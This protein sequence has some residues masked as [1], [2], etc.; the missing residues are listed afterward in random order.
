[1]NTLLLGKILLIVLITLFV[2]LIIW[3]YL[4]ERKAY[5]NGKCPK[6]NK[7]LRNFDCDSQGGRGYCCD[8]CNY[9]TWISYSSIDKNHHKK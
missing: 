9:H 1:M 4:S 3:G 8:Y 6:C 2:S 7:K 5:N